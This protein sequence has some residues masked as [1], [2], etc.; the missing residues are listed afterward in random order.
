MLCLHNNKKNYQYF[1]KYTR[2]VAICLREH[3]PRQQN[4]Y[5]FLAIFRRP[6]HRYREAIGIGKTIF[7]LLSLKMS[8]LGLKWPNYKFLWLCL[9]VCLS[10]CLED[11]YLRTAEPILTKFSPKILDRL[12]QSWKAFGHHWHTARG[13]FYDFK[14]LKKSYVSTDANFFLSGGHNTLYFLLLK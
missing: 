1:V 11:D 2:H 5:R 10:V 3:L 4:S 6:Y 7:F 14:T 8:Y 12:L 9:S 13:G